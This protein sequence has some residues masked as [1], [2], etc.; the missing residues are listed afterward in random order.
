MTKSK[1]PNAA[2]FP[3]GV[4]GPAL[5]A[6]DGAGIRSLADLSAW[7]EQ[8]LADLHGIGPK[9]LGVLKAALQAEG[10]NLRTG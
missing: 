2:T 1:H 5:R 8:E 4:S 10:R 6:L 9:A 7:S 3:Q